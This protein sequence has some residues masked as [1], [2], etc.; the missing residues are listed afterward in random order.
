MKESLKE[1]DPF[2]IKRDGAISDNGRKEGMLENGSAIDEKR[3]VMVLFERFH[4]SGVYTNAHG[5]LQS[6]D[7]EVHDPLSPS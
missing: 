6:Y 7:G 4:G 1:M 3:K 2:A 5:P